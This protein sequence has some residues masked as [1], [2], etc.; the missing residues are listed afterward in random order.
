MILCQVKGSVKV[1][2]KDGKTKID[3][4]QMVYTRSKGDSNNKGENIQIP[5][6]D[7][8]KESVIENVATFKKL[9]I[10]DEVSDARKAVGNP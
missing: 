3:P 6:A 1:I 5:F 10:D 8:K 7:R 2:E 9:I 4:D